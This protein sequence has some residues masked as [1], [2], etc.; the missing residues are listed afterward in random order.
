MKSF[1][2]RDLLKAHPISAFLCHSH[3]DRDAIHALYMR[4]KRDSVK[5]WL[6]QEK[7]LPG[8]NWKIEIRKAI[9]KSDVVIVCLSRTFNQE[10][11]FRHE[12]INIALK[13]AGLFSADEIYIIPVR[14]EKCD[15]PDSLCHLH[16][17]D[18]FEKDGYKKLLHSLYRHAEED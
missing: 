1:F 5:A 7:L 13:K 12:E 15:L 8:Q 18:L 3:T 2:G 4:L 11:G 9:L 10:K 16:R 14:L 17:V 6:D